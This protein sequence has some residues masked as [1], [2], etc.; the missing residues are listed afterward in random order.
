M[1]VILNAVILRGALTGIGHY[2]EHLAAGLEVHPEVDRVL[3]FSRF[4]FVSPRPRTVDAGGV[5]VVRS[6]L[7][8]SSVV[9][10]LYGAL[11]SASFRIQSGWMKASLYH[12]PNYILM[13]FSG[14]AVSTFHDL[15]FVH[16]PQYHPA[17]RVRRMDRGMPHTLA[18]AAHLITDSEFVRQELIRICGVRPDKVTSIPLGV[19]PTFRPLSKEACAPALARHGLSGTGYLL[20]VATQEPR[21]NLAGLVAAYA[22]LPAALQGRFPLV[23]AGEKGWLS[24]PLEALAAPLIQRG[25]I[26]RLGYVP[27]E[28]LPALYAGASAFAFPSFYEG[29]GLPVLEAMASGVP[30][31]ISNRASLPEVGGEVCLQV[32]PDD[33]SSMTSGLER[34]LSDENFREKARLQGPARAREFSWGACVER[35]V[36]IYR[37]VLKT[38]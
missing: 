38:A 2:A 22:A 8:R 34:L 3:Y 14:P 33:V 12:E 20:S 31:L 9:D 13:P 29:F 17:T 19:D 10:G 6:R 28:D 16:F 5:S 11:R 36:S 23:L 25:D 7:K 24:G 35:T 30:T 37:Q 1:R 32:D 27:L 15:S 21:K 18:S 26:R 4:R